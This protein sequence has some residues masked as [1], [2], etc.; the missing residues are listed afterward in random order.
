M[1]LAI[2]I[3]RIGTTFS[4]DSFT[5]CGVKINGWPVCFRFFL[6]YLAEV[7][8]RFSFISKSTC[9]WKELISD[10]WGWLMVLLASISFDFADVTC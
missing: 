1:P 5:I 9:L 10:P 8:S 4:G 2:S 6:L 7:S 3:F